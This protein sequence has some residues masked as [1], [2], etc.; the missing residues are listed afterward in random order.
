MKKCY[1][2][3]SLSILGALVDAK[4]PFWE[5][6]VKLQAAIKA[7][8]SVK[9]KSLIRDIETS[10]SSAEDKIAVLVDLHK[11]AVQATAASKTVSSYA[12][13]WRDTWKTWLGSY[14]LF[15]EASNYMNAEKLATQ[16]VEI[17][18]KRLE[19][20]KKN[21][22]NQSDF[23]MERDYDWLRQ[24][25]NYTDQDWKNEIHKR[26]ES[27]K[28]WSKIRAV[29][30]LIPLYYGLKASNQKAVIEK[31][32]EIEHFISNKLED[33]KTPV[34]VHAEEVNIDDQEEEIEE[35]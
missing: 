27:K 1:L 29:I 4:R 34:V 2:I 8:D 33:L 35:L 18:K 6:F 9:V 25:E 22:P 14:W 24:F 12:M 13:N 19:T 5:E 30:S 28:Y 21:T 3:A 17:V 32:E 26:A 31:A 10:N 7:H 11:D 23:W 20:A 15:S 16:G